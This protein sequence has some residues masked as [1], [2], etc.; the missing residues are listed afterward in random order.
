MDIFNIKF[1]YCDIFY[2]KIDVVII[3]LEEYN[4]VKYFVGMEMCDK[5][6]WINGEYMYFILYIN[7]N[8]FKNFCEKMRR[9]FNLG[10]KNNKNNKFYYGWML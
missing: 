1:G 9:I 3:M 8:D 7:F 6:D 2:N 10:S 4:I 5:Y